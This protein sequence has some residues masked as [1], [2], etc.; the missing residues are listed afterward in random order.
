MQRNLLPT[1]LVWSPATFVVRKK[2]FI[3]SAFICFRLLGLL[4]FWLIIN[5][6]LVCWQVDARLDGLRESAIANKEFLD[7]HV[8]SM[9]GITTD[10]KRKWQSFSTQAE[11]DAKDGAVY[12]AAKHCRME[13]LLQQW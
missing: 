9:E 5:L 8:S 12:S 13:V 7:G 3:S 4:I 10:A 2:W 1:F 6:I 11:N